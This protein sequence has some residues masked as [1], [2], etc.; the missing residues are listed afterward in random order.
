MTCLRRPSVCSFY[1]WRAYVYDAR[2]WSKPSEIRT[3][4]IGPVTT[5]TVE[6][7]VDFLNADGKS[8]ATIK[9]MITDSEDNPITDELVEMSVD[10]G[11]EIS[12]VTNNNDGTYTA[13]YT[14]GTTPGTVTITAKA[15]NSNVF[16]TVEIKL[17]E[18]PPID[19]ATF[20]LR[21]KK[22]LNMISLP[23]KP[24]TPYTARSFL[25]KLNATVIITYDTSAGKFTPF[26][27]E[28]NEDDVFEIEGGQGYIV[29]LPEYKEVTFE[30]TVWSNAPSISTVRIYPS[31][32]WAFLV[33]G[34]LLSEDGKPAYG[35][36]LVVCRNRRTGRLSSDMISSYGEGKFI[37]SFVDLSRKSV[38][39]TG[40]IIEVKILDERQKV[41]AGPIKHRVS[42]KEIGKAYALVELRLSEI[43]PDRNCLLQ[44][45]PNPFNPE[46]WIPFR[47]AEM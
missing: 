26:I 1:Q 40:D 22:G 44:N 41:I 4:T 24:D 13:T 10:G 38:V 27:P 19:Y 18:G 3:F 21:L 2:L 11:G 8:T 30:G 36:Y 15:T 46:T 29:N 12:E 20:T 33:G 17:G 39:E 25:E 28:V 31:S 7:S 16:G 23:V 42:K 5:I 35:D 43:I 14:A 6:S 45:Y 34:I 47:L 9:A 37:G 32:A